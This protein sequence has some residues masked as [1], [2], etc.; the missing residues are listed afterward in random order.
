[1][2]P[3]FYVLRST[4]YVLRSTFYVLRAACNCVVAYDVLG[5]A[6]QRSMFHVERLRRGGDDLPGNVPRGTK[7]FPKRRFGQPP[8]PTELVRVRKIGNLP[9]ATSGGAREQKRRDGRS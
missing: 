7:R 8:I 9:R 5:A 2:R 4:F 1:M 6:F 3:L